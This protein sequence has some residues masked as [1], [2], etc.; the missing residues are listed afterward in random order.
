[1]PGQICACLRNKSERKSCHFVKSSTNT[2]TRSALWVA[3]KKAREEI[4]PVIA[5]G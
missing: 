1:M 5:W 4:S 2:E 3:E